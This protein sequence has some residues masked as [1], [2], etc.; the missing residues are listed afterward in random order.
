ML[1]QQFLFISLVSLF[2]SACTQSPVEVVNRGGNSY[3]RDNAYVE[4]SGPRSYEHKQAGFTPEFHNSTYSEDAP[5]SSVGVSDLQ[6]I[7]VSPPQ[8]VSVSPVAPMETNDVRPVTPDPVI[9]A[10]A[11]PRNDHILQVPQHTKSIA[12]E[13]PEHIADVAPLPALEPVKEIASAKKTG[14]IWPVQ[15][16]VIS[17]YG[18][19]SAGEFND[20]IN[21]AAAEGEPVWAVADGEVI[22]AGEMKDYGKMV[23]VKHTGGV[24]TSYAHVSDIPVKKGDKV[25]QGDMV[26]YVGSTGTVK[27]SQ[28]F[29]TVRKGTDAVNPMPYLNNEI[30]SA[31][32]G[33]P[34]S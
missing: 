19:K 18:K 26:A 17:T 25:Q 8:P 16:D 7:T 6:P 29:F 20:G 27:T 28:L 24:S 11:E 23:I 9:H 5:M 21:I 15:G 14:F 31:S 2:I 30:A 10:K 32:E 13:E 3:S 1:R 22:Y 34:E 4:N 12:S 33:K